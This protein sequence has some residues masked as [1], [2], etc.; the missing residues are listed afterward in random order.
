MELEVLAAVEAVE[1]QVERDVQRPGRHLALA[2]AEADRLA[3]LAAEVEDQFQ[4]LAAD[5]ARGVDGGDVADRPHRQRVRVAEGAQ[6]VL[7]VVEVVVDVFGMDPRVNLQGAAVVGAAQRLGAHFVEALAEGV[8]LVGLDFQPGR[9]RV[10]AVAAEERRAAVQVLEQVEVRDAPARA[11]ADPVV[12]DPDDH[13]RPVEAARDAAG[14]DAHHARVPVRMR[15]HDA[16]IARRVELR[17][18][19]LARLAD[20]AVLDLLALAARFVELLRE[21][22]RA[23]LALGEHQLQRGVRVAEAPGGV[24]ARA[25]DEAD[26]VR[27]HRPRD[28]RRLDERAQAH[29]ARAVEQDEP[30]V[31]EDSVLAEQRHDVRDGPHRDQFHETLEIHLRRRLDAAPPSLLEEPVADLER[32]AHAREHPDVVRAA[33]E[34]GIDHRAGFRDAFGGRLV[35]VGD[36]DVD[37]EPRGLAHRLDG[38]RPAVHRDDE[39]RVVVLHAPVERIHAEPVS[40]LEPVRQE[41]RRDRAEPAEHLDHERGGGDAVH[42]VVAV[43]EDGAALLD[44]RPDHLDG[45]LHSGQHEGIRHVGEA[46]LEEGI[47]VGVGGEPPGDER[48]GH[49]ARE[50]VRLGDVGGDGG[51]GGSELPTLFGGNEHGGGPFFRGAS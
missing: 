28:A 21:D 49:G 45:L 32:D 43:D 50:P 46:G 19:R 11:A 47:D 22:A 42:V 37:A 41:R 48:A 51:I 25:D 3:L 13:R 1:E 39:I 44:V 38:R 31:D 29:R 2:H 15:H 27:V 7:V 20:D 6:A 30:V 8:D 4:V 5:D 26:L 16:V 24:D 12:V 40:V 35:V 18:E 10:P 17:V 34:L 23:R 9:H 36:D 14:D 33:A